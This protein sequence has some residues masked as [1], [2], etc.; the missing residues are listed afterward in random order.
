[1]KIAVVEKRLHNPDWKPGPGRVTVET[2]ENLIR[3]PLPANRNLANLRIVSCIKIR[4]KIK[5][6]TCLNKDNCFSKGT[7]RR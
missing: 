4:T 5:V 1:M 3:D 2:S 7:K 6:M